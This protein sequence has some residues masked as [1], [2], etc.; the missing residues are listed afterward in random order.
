MRA[1][2]EF[3]MLYLTHFN[4]NLTLYLTPQLTDYRNTKI[5]C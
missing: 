1:I 4:V 5:N 2:Y 3:M